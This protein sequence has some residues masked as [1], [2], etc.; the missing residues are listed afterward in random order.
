MEYR[1][2]VYEAP[3]EEKVSHLSKAINIRPQLAQ[4]L[5]QRGIDSFDKAKA[6]F[7]P[8]L[9]QLHDPFLMK[10]MDKAVNRL[11][12]AIH[13]NEKILI[14]GD[15]DVD[16]TTS[17]ALL[18]RFLS[19]H[20]SA[21]AYYIPDRYT[22]GYG[23]SM[24]GIDWANENGYQ[25]I[26]ALDCGITAVEQSK[27]AAKYG[28]DLIICDHHLPGAQLPAAHA[29]LNPK[30]PDCG[31][32]FKELSGC[33]V[34]FKL[35]QGFCVQ[36]TIPTS[37]LVQYMDLVAVSIAS[38][39][40]EITG[41][42]RTLCSLGLAQLNANPS[43][44]LNA[45]IDLISLKRKLTVTDVVFYIGPR[46][47]AA[48]RLSHAKDSVELLIN[49]SADKVSKQA[50][51]LDQR[52]ADRK[53]YDRSMTTEAIQMIEE[54]FS[55][56]NSTVLFDP[57]W[58]KG[59]VGIVASRC[60]EKYYRP[61]IILTSS[62]GKATG[63]ARSV[64][65]F[66]IYNAIN[67]CSDLLEQFGGHAHAAGLTLSL[68][69]VERFREKFEEVVSKTI[70]PEQKQP[71]LDLDLEVDFDFINIKTYRIMEQMAPFGPGNMTPLFMTKNV[72]FKEEARLI[73]DSHFKAKLYQRG[74][75]QTLEAIGF[76][77]GDWVE[78]LKPNHPF[79]IVYHIDEN[80]FQGNKNLQLIIKD[81]KIV[82]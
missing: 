22:E 80:E 41:E 31:Y 76:G 23:I 66:N 9:D 3:E 14:Y 50:D 18:H 39:L 49:P 67:A 27:L 19:K 60:I 32:P 30:R 78:K 42:N 54:S 28:I 11:T 45:I 58:H 68:D 4:M 37:E 57:E 20:T 75:D 10:D 62:N 7:R 72:Y 55:A 53:E 81:I 51:V 16:G 70:K 5:V 52:N 46:I 61:T 13:T 6:F 43:P 17:V 40:V 64:N 71:V 65:G 44:G 48:G 36:N 25:L 26:I 73:K 15:Y 77:L 21:H 56:C 1:W 8:T 63:S 74:F 69:K 38:D 24:Q 59:V 33:G 12:E 34:G 29:I 2:L 79:N 35:L 47:N 82:A